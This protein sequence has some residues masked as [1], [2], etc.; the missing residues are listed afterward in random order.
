[1]S[2]NCSNKILDVHKEFLFPFTSLENKFSLNIPLSYI[3]IRSM[4]IS[5]FYQ[6][7]NQTHT[8]PIDDYLFNQPITLKIDYEDIEGNNY[9]KFYICQQDF[10]M[11]KGNKDGKFLKAIGYLNL[12]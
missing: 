5:Y 11:Y 2:I 12:I 8:E 1:M 6:E 4:F 10:F 9:S 7:I 3:I